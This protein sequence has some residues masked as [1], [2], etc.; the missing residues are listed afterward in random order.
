MTLRGGV[1]GGA[2][3]PALH[4][5]RASVLCW[6]GAGAGLRLEL[7]CCARFLRALFCLLSFLRPG[8]SFSTSTQHPPDLLYHP[9]LNQ[10]AFSSIPH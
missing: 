3:D 6:P 5:P 9:L 10:P 8:S 2:S 1:T 7:F 4:L